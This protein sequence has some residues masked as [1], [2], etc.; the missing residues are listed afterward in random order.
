MWTNPK[1]TGS[2][3]AK[4]DGKTVQVSGNFLNKND[5]FI[6]WIYTS[7]NRDTGETKRLILVNGNYEEV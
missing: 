3:L 5:D 4:N 6:S 1:Q 7:T 2:Y